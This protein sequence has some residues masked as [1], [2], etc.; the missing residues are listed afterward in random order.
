MKKTIF[1]L[2]SLILCLLLGA[3]GDD[4]FDRYYSRPT[5]LEPPIYEMLQEDGRFTCYLTCVDKTLYARILKSAS[6]YTVFAPTDSAFAIYLNGRSINDISAAEADTI[7]GYSMVFNTFEFGELT[8]ILT[9]G[10]D[11]LASIKKKTAFYETIHKEA[12]QGDSVWVLDAT[13]TSTAVIGENNYKFIP[14]YMAAIF[15]KRSLTNLDYETFYD[16]EYTGENIQGA[17]AVEKDMFAENGIVHAVD[18]VNKPLSNLEKLMEAEADYAEVVNVLNRKNTGGEYIYKTYLTADALTAYYKE[19]YPDSNINIVYVKFYDLSRLALSPNTER[20]GYTDALAESSGYTLVLPSNNGVQHF[21]EEKI[22]PFAGM[23]GYESID[24][25]PSSLMDYFLNS[26]M[27]SSL[28]WPSRFANSMNANGEF[29]NG[30]G[31]N[32]KTFTDMNFKSTSV[33]S[34][35]FLYALDDTS[36]IH[37][38]QFET[39]YAQL[40][41]DT[42]YSWMRNAINTATYGGTLPDQLMCSKLNGYNSEYYIVLLM[43]NSA[44]INNHYTMSYDNEYVFSNTYVSGTLSAAERMKRLLQSCVIVRIKNTAMDN[45]LEEMFASGHSVSPTPC[46]SSYG[47]HVVLNYYGDMVRIKCQTSAARQ[48]KIQLQMLGKYDGE[49]ASSYLVALKKT[50]LDFNNGVAYGLDAQYLLDYANA[51][52]TW[53]ENS[54]GYYLFNSTTGACTVNTNLSTWKKYAMAVTLFDVNGTVYSNPEEILE[55]DFVTILIPNNTAMAKAVADGY[56]PAYDALN[57]DANMQKARNFLLHHILQGRVFINDLNTDNVIY[58]HQEASYSE[59]VTN[60]T[61]Y[62]YNKQ[63]MLVDVSKDPDDGCLRF[64][65]NASVSNDDGDPVRV[66]YTKGVAAS[67]IKQS[68]MYARRGV[69]HEIDG[70][71]PCDPIQE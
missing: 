13:S 42:T 46:F 51:P 50:Q 39:V 52:T 31:S 56:L 40:L 20:V 60:P 26:H 7:V 3:C 18:R 68:N 67:S 28:I 35:G 37:P 24:D 55:T 44:L 10:W 45:T 58:N 4:E 70:Y 49:G 25:V 27:A 53:E 65:T 22:G 12:Y 38:K 30:L 64:Q 69:I 5:W 21:Y 1:S 43:A 54:L 32:G 47:Y 8:D 33:A 15:N 41:L 59:I 23:Y 2:M 61:Y 34:N 11:T 6:N 14:T 29:F 48:K 17:T 71:L 36:Y 66:V 62:T 9:E 19:L 16:R 63:S 57:T